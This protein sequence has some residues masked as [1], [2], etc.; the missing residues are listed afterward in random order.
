MFKE[1]LSPWAYGRMLEYVS[2]NGFGGSRDE[3][4][5]EKD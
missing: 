4:Q 1:T 5:L 2:K 3:D